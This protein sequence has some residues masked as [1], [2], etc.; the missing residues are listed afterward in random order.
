VKIIMLV[1]TLVS[2][3]AFLMGF[4]VISGYVLGLS[5]D[6]GRGR[7]D[8]IPRYYVR[9]LLRIYPA[10]VVS[11]VF[12]AIVVLMSDRVVPAAASPMFGQMFSAPV[13]VVSLVFNWFLIRIELNGIAWT[14]ALE[15]AVSL[16]FPVLYWTSRHPAKW[17][18]VVALLGLI[19]ISLVV[20]DRITEGGLALVGGTPAGALR[21]VLVQ[22]SYVPEILN[23]LAFYG[24][25]FYLGLIGEQVLR[26]VVPRIDGPSGSWLAGL[27]LLVTVWSAGATTPALVLVE[28]LGV[29]FLVFCG[30]KMQTR[31]WLTRTL[32]SRFF[33]SLGTVSFSFYLYHFIIINVVGSVMFRLVDPVFVR[34]NPLVFVLGLFVLTFA[35]T[36]G[37]AAASYRLVERPLM[38]YSKRA[39]ASGRTTVVAMSMGMVLVALLPLLAKDVSYVAPAQV[40][41]VTTGAAPTLG[42]PAP[43]R[44]TLP[45][46]LTFGDSAIRR[47][48]LSGWNDAEVARGRSFSWSE[49]LRSVLSAPIPHDR[50]VRMDFEALPFVYQGSPPQHVTIVLNGTQIGDIALGPGLQRYSV[51]MPAAALR[52]AVD[53]IELR[54]AYARRPKDVINTATDS[55]TLA[56]AWYSIDFAVQEPVTEQR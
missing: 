41:A 39:R 56:V 22:L 44:V 48:M 35:V 21:S 33:T 28:A 50:D 11:I 23:N 55:R 37:V 14:L 13:S 45:V 27:V 26:T 19:A 6:A 16:L 36:A 53:V 12:I 32:D 43:D 49:G 51:S 31:N 52:D 9:R 20:G 5:L 46:H 4:F 25:L 54:Y 2:G 42:L 30:A 7:A 38:E 8:N 40:A 3:H 34:T 15:M 47:W 29:T 18:R 17:I 1:C 24:Y 10:H